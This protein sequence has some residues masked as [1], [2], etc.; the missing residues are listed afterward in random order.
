MVPKWLTKWFPKWVLERSRCDLQRGTLQNEKSSPRCR[1]S[2]IFDIAAVPKSLYFY[3][4]FH[5]KLVPKL[6]PKRDPFRNPLF[7]RFFARG[8]V[9]SHLKTTSSANFRK[10]EPPFWHPFWLKICKNGAPL[11]DPIGS[12][13]EA[14]SV[15][16]SW[17]T[18][19]LSK[20]AFWLPGG[21][22]FGLWVWFSAGFC[23][24]TALF[25]GK[26]FGKVAG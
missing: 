16:R 10:N 19:W 6:V 8:T 12:G 13:C 23:I 15:W 24:Q 7:S 1:E 3:W 2:M 21:H 5:P 17:G 9:L 18:P 26:M 25:Y 14:A 22:V 20:T 4:K 11:T